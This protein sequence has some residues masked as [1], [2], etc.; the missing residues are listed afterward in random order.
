MS[1]SLTEALFGSA[2]STARAENARRFGTAR[3]SRRT[4]TSQARQSRNLYALV[5]SEEGR[6]LAA[7]TGT[8][9]AVKRSVQ[10]KPAYVRQALAGKPFALSGVQRAGLAAPA[11]GYAQPFPTR[12]GRRVLISGLDAKLIYEFLGGYLKKVPNIKGGQAYVLDRR[13]GVVAS[14]QA[15]RAP[16][17]VVR[18]KGLLAA[19][20]KD[21]RGSFGDDNYFASDGVQGAPWRVVV[22]VSEENLFAS[23]N[24]SRKWVPWALFIAFGIAAVLALVL[25]RRVLRS[26]AKLTR[27]QLASWPTPTRRSSGVPAS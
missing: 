27:R 22:T 8:P 13:G 16:G 1:A 18:E 23:V 21:S 4:L 12:F 24:G 11:L 9:A 7:S 2:G 6:L 26:A 3:V 5:L 15:G 20:A 14:P 25:L 19:L 17:E 10:A